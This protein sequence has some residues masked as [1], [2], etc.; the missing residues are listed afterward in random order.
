MEAATTPTPPPP[1]F[2]VL[3][4]KW[5]GPYGGVPPFSQIKV[6]YFKPALLAA[7]EQNRVEI[8]AIANNPAAPTFE[9]TIAAL[10][11]AGRPLTN[12]TALFGVFSSAMNDDA[13]QAVEREMAPKLAA[14]ADE[15]IQNTALF[16]RIESVYD[17]PEKAKLTPEQVGS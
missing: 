11:D 13:F 7:M 10:E 6:E 16:K 14:F 2:H 17:S 8:A 5:T 1:D 3:L 12:V 15:I 9:N 4:A